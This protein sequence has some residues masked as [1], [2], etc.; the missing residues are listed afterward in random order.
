MRETKRITSGFELMHAVYA[1]E[2]FLHDLQKR[3]CNFDIIFFRDLK[4]ICALPKE[5][6]EPYKGDLTRAVLFQHLARSEIRS[7]VHEFD[8]FESGECRKHLSSRS[9][10]FIICHEGYGDEG[11]ETV[12][13]HHLIWKFASSGKHVFVTLLSQTKNSTD[14]PDHDTTVFQT[15]RESS[16]IETTIANGYIEPNDSTTNLTLREWI[17]INFICSFLEDLPPDMIHRAV[18]NDIHALLLHTAALRMCHLQ[19]R[20]CETTEIDFNSKVFLRLFSIICI[21][22]IE[23]G[24]KSGEVSWDLFDMTDGRIISFMVNRVK[25]NEP[26]PEGIMKVACSLWKEVT[27]LKPIYSDSQVDIALQ[28]STP[29]SLP[30]ELAATPPAALAFEHPTFNKYVGNIKTNKVKVTD[31]AASIV[32]EDLNHWRSNKTVISWKSTYKPGF[33][34]RKRK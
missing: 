4:S 8:S 32:S 27:R 24:V 20:R 30:A 31:P 9:W 7:G 19:D 2:K 15:L 1:V 34:A 33:F 13:L 28:L 11:P 14:I 25:T 10:H 5:G 16:V 22:W 23:R 29:S 18:M 6:T 26:V 12:L 3:G 21:E 17:I